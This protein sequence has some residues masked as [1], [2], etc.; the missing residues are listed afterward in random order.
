MKTRHRIFKGA[1]V[2]LALLLAIL[3][4]FAA[5][6]GSPMDA[7][8][9][10]AAAPDSPQRTAPALGGT[11]T[12]EWE[13]AADEAAPAAAQEAGETGNYDSGG[14]AEA[15]GAMPSTGSNG[16]DT[17]ITQP[18]DGRK[19]ILNVDIQM[20]TLEFDETIETIRS[21]IASSGGF[22]AAATV[23]DNSIY[24]SYSG[25]YATITARVPAEK[26]TSFLQTAAAAGNVTY[27]NE[28]SQDVTSDYVDLEARLTAL[29][30]QEARLLELMAVAADMQDIILIQQQLSDVQYEIEYYT[31]LQ[32]TYDDLV[33]YSTI[34]LYVSEVKEWTPPEPETFGSRIVA[35]LRNTWRNVV[36]GAK[37][38]VIF[39]IGALP[40]LIFLAVIAVVVILLVKRSRRLR[41]QK[42][43]AAP[44]NIAAPPSAV[45]PPAVDQP[46]AP[47]TPEQKPKKK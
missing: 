20:E 11:D 13:S 32:R 21:A 19:V 34:V 22:I 10:A 1:G 26:Y 23:E 33:A 7:Q 38:F 30:A 24:N 39:F 18:Q 14:T 6:G 35:A 47:E 36:E 40:A 42:A 8:S 12:D 28:Y 45:A 16:T 9:T 25:R 27:R 4:L 41:R 29:K 37:D 46:A 3:L 44:Q 31:S 2:S 15:T 17:A 5:C 43:A